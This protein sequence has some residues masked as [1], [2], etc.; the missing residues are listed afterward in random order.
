MTTSSSSTATTAAAD[1]SSPLQLL[2]ID[3]P[4]DENLERILALSN[5]IFSPDG[6]TKHSSLQHWRNQLSHPSSF[7]V[8]LVPSTG[9][10]EPVAFAFVEYRAHDSPLKSGAAE[11][12]HVW[13]A[14][15]SPHWRKTGCLTRL[16]QEL[17]GIETLT[18]CTIPARFPDMWKWLTRRGWIQEQEL[19]EDKV[20]F[21]RPD[22]L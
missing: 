15:T 19:A 2:R 4:D 3:S 12:L 22:I 10:T 11:S 7:I 5:S 8:Y 20:M 21:S 9:P 1:L 13:L 16:F 14:G 6:S 17:R 18:I